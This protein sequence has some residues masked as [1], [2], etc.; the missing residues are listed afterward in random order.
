MQ[1][2][3]FAAKTLFFLDTFITYRQICSFMVRQKIANMSGVGMTEVG[4]GIDYHPGHSARPALNPDEM[5]EFL[6]EEQ[7]EGVHPSLKGKHF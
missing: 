7:R 6:R 5:R 2:S 3:R 1:G 4:K